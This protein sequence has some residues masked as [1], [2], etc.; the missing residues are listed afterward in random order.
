MLLVSGQQA[1]EWWTAFKINLFFALRQFFSYFLSMWLAGGLLHF[2]LYFVR[3][4]YVL[5]LFFPHKVVWKTSPAV[6]AH[7][8]CD[9]VSPEGCFAPIQPPPAQ[10][11]CCLWKVAYKEASL[12]LVPRL[13]LCASHYLQAEKQQE[14]KL[15]YSQICFEIFRPRFRTSLSS[16]TVIF[17]QKPFARVIWIRVLEWVNQYKSHRVVPVQLTYCNSLQK[18]GGEDKQPQLFHP[19]PPPTTQ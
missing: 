18:S 9:F 6:S 19:P 15:F 10:C 12:T 16:T 17:G 7:S 5:V 8:L 11:H 3:I 13:T 1:S 2:V 4:F 14:L